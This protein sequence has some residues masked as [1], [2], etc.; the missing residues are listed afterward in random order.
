M[1]FHILS[2]E[3]SDSYARVGGLATRIEGLTE[4]LAGAGAPTHLWF[5][6]DPDLPVR[7]ATHVR[8]VLE[9]EVGRRSPDRP[10]NP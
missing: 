9:G 5:V 4:A 2:F 8:R 3:G 7:R 6:G 10:A 1:Q